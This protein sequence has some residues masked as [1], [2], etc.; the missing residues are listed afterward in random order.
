MSPQIISVSEFIEIL[1]ETL[2]FAFPAVVIEGEVSEFRISQ[3]KWVSFSLKDE[4]SAINCFMVAAQLKVPLEDGMKIR[5]TGGPRVYGKSGRLSFSV[6]QVDLAGEGEI[7][8]AFELLKRKLE[9]EG[10][11]R[12]ERKRSIS[13]YPKRIGLITSVDSAAYADFMKI[14]NSRWGGVTLEVAHV[15][16]Q[17]AAAPDQ[18][19]AAFAY[20]NQLA[21][22]VDTLV[23][24][25]GG[26]SLEDLQAFNTEPVARAVAGSRTPTI[27][28]VGHEVDTSLADFAADLRAATPT[29]AAQLVVPDRREEQAK[30]ESAIRHAMVSLGR[31]LAERSAAVDRQLNRIELFV[32]RPLEQ[33]ASARH[34]LEQ[35]ALR[36]LSGAARRGEQVSRWQGLM[37]IR[38]EQTTERRRRSLEQLERIIRT[39]SPQATLARGYSI[40]RHGGQ[41]V[42]DAKNVRAGDTVMVQLS[43]GNLKAEVSE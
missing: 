1:N 3:G 26:G 38:M 13:R 12:P 8:R 34:Q 17:G 21:E 28:G 27:V 20:F 10:L 14:L 29:N 37:A 41:I 7:R 18:V 24:I 22:P 15:Q 2:G 16:V 25:R 32:R 40:V 36:L 6:R 5:V 43:K 23:L 30:V 33:V 35:S 39:T 31:V 19:V 9:A 42:R 4:T 11:F